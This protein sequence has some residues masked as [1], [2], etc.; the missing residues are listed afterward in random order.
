VEAKNFQ[1]NLDAHGLMFKSFKFLL[2]TIEDEH[3][4]VSAKNAKTYEAWTSLV[5]KVDI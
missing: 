4:K 1:W 5:T 2:E 3:S